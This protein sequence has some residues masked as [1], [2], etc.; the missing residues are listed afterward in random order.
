VIC[1]FSLALSFLAPLFA[2]I[3][4][5]CFKLNSHLVKQHVARKELVLVLF[6]SK[7]FLLCYSITY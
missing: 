4:W 1:L 3:I 2:N 5:C 6:S 7:G